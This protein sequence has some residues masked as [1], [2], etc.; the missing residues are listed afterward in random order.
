VS[1]VAATSPAK[2]VSLA[3]SAQ[4]LALRTTVASLTAL[5]WQ[6]A[7]KLG[8]WLGRLGYFPLGIRRGVV[9]SQ[10]AMVFPAMSPDEVTRVS[11]AAYAHL[12]RTAIETALLPSLRRD[13]ILDLVEGI[14]GW[15]VIEGALA[16]GRGVIL[17]TG[18]LGNWELAGAYL[19]ARGVRVGAV[20]RHMANPRFDQ[21]LNMTRTSHGIKVMYD[22]EAVRATPRVLRQGYLIAF[23]ADQGVRGLAS[24]FVPFFG[25]PAKTPRGPAVFAL[26]LGVPVVFGAS[27]RQP[28]GKYR[29]AFETVEVT[30]T[31]DRERDVD[32]IVARYTAALERWV[33]IAPEQ[34]LW[35]HRRWKRQPPGAPAV[36]PEPA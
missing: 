15:D 3:H 12:G 7:G 28:G 16:P 17:V 13:E 22:D 34:Y 8:A 32:T 36:L 30:D 4:Y 23:L 29:L 21:Y 27:I 19:A 35:H 2:R 11:K 25:R 10:V 20:V 33:R 31:G 1:D 6:R 14:E 24:T 5:P 9:E 18:H 26:R